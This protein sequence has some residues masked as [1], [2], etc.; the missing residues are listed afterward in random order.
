MRFKG[1][2]QRKYA[3]YN[4]PGSGFDPVPPRPQ[5]AG[6]PRHDPERDYEYDPEEHRLR[7]PDTPGYTVG[8]GYGDVP[9][10]RG[11][12]YGVGPA[13]YQRPDESI[14]EEACERLAWESHL[15]ASDI[16]VTVENGEITLTGEVD[17]RQTKRFAEHILD[18][19]RGIHDVHNR[20]TIRR[21]EDT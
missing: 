15:D 9:D 4:T 6:E 5:H 13:G 20:L 18:D 3:D 17:D 19:I 21:D 12:F 1:Y 16:T 2:R 11:P 14:Y 10:E 7:D 8:S